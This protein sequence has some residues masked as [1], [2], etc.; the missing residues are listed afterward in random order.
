MKIMKISNTTRDSSVTSFQRMLQILTTSMCAQSTHSFL[1]SPAK[2]IPMQDFSKSCIAQ[3]A[4]QIASTLDIMAKQR[5]T[6]A[7]H[8]LLVLERRTQAIS[9]EFNS[10]AVASTLWAFAAMWTKPGKRMMGQLER[11]AE[12]ISGECNSLNF[13]NKLWAFATMEKRPGERMMGQM[14]RLFLSLYIHT[15]IHTDE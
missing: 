15:Y 6:A 5:Y 11:R 4:Q 8:L 3:E 12:A 1:P 9:G 13:A 14:E 10:Q 7:G 2:A